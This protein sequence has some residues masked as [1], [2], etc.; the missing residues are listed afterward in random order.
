MAGVPIGLDMGTVLQ[1][2]AARQVDMGLLADVLPAVEA[3][4]LTG[5]DGDMSGEYDNG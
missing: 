2:G 5:R 3:A 4:I 1:M